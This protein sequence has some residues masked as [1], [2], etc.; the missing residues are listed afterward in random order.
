MTHPYRSPPD[1]A[2]V[3]HDNALPRLLWEGPLFPDDKHP[4]YRE[5][6]IR[7]VRVQE[8]RGNDLHTYNT[9][10]IVTAWSALGEPQWVL[11]TD[12]H[13]IQ[14][15]LALAAAFGGS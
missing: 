4:P 2:V 14:A 8:Q 3:P 10:E 7:V 1:A 13:H 15:I 12:T 9:V 5:P 6:R 11:V